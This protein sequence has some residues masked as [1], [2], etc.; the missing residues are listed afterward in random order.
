MMRMEVA[1][2][3]GM[4]AALSISSVIISCAVSVYT[5]TPHTRTRKATNAHFLQTQGLLQYLP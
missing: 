3:I 4:R 2:N 5:G 1:F